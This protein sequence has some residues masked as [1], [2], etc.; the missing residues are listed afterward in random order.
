MPI[1]VNAEI[2]TQEDPTS[3]TVRMAIF[4]STVRHDYEREMLTAKRLAE[5]SEASLRVLQDA[6]TR[7][8]AASTDAQLSAALASIARD[9]FAASEVAVLLA[10]ERGNF[11]VSAGEQHE[12]VIRQL[13]AACPID[14]LYTSVDAVISIESLDE[15][16]TESALVGDILRSM[17]TEALTAVPIAEGDSILGAIVCFYG[18]PRALD[19]QVLELHRALARQASLVLSRVRLQN[20][21]ERLAR[22]DPLTGLANRTLLTERISRALEVS[23][24]RDHSIAIIFIDLD[25]FKAIN[26][27]LGHRVGDMVLKTVSDRMRVAVRD[28]DIV[29]RFGGDEFVIVCEDADAEVARAIADRLAAAVREPIPTLAAEFRVT[30][31]VGVALHGSGSDRFETAESLV[32]RADATMYESK[33]SGSDRITLSD[34]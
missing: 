28:T 31:S 24:S 10:D 29:G 18:R 7:F 27:R 16:Y 22:Y 8:M 6:S 32:L 20:Q 34:S 3:A 25:G 21:L 26:D 9:A 17:R 4:D 13:I 14:E 12:E 23:R 11:R 19:Q 33:R 15:A 1:L 2:P 30:A 5:T